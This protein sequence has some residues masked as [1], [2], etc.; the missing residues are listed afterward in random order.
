[1]YPHGHSI[2]TDV[3]NELTGI[4]LFASVGTSRMN[5]ASLLETLIFA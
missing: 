5:L 4:L 3:F 2:S 1:M